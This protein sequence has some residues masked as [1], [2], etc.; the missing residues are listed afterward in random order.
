MI[1]NRAV[2]PKLRFNP[3]IRRGNFK[4]NLMSRSRFSRFSL[5]AAAVGALAV[6]AFAVAPSRAA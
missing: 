4:E 6:A 2:S 3:V 1:A 5:C